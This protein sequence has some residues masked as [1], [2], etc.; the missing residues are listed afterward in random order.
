MINKINTEEVETPQILIYQ[1]S[2]DSSTQSCRANE[3]DS[4][5]YSLGASFFSVAKNKKCFAKAN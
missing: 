1:L 5:V 4:M 3:K 2:L